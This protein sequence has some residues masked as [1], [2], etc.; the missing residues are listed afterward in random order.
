MPLPRHQ[1]RL[2]CC[3]G[4]DL[5]VLVVDGEEL[6]GSEDFLLEERIIDSHLL[7]DLRGAHE[8]LPDDCE[9]T[10]CDI[11]GCVGAWRDGGHNGDTRVG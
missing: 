2:I 5:N 1:I 7:H 8:F 6:D 9:C 3:S 4:R 11:E 10:E